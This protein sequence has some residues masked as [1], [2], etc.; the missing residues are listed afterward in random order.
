MRKLTVLAAAAVLTLAL[1]SKAEASLIFVTNIDI[2]GTGL[3]AVNTL[4]TVHDS[5]GGSPNTNGI[6]GGCIQQS[7]AIGPPCEGEVTE[8]DNIALNQTFTFDTSLNF[9]AVVNISETGQDKAATLTGLYLE[10]CSTI[11]PS[12]CHLAEWTEDAQRVLSSL[13]GEGTGLGASGFTFRLSDA[14]FAIVQGLDGDLVTVSGGLQFLG[15]STDDGNETL[16]VLRVEGNQV[17]PE[18]ATLAL[19][20]MGIAAGLVRRRRTGR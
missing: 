14:E 17:V 20:G 7:N 16:H 4:V 13:S 12:D 6:E 5:G 10:F 1:A 3:G 15:G 9:V 8:N 18:P 19:L 11:N 2:T